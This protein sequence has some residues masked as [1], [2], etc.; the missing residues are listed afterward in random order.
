MKIALPGDVSLILSRLE[1]AG[2]EAY[3]VGGCIRDS[4]LGKV[5]KDWDV[6]TNAKPLEVKA[7]FKKSFDTG[8]EHGTVTVLLGESGYEITTYRVDGTYS[9]GRHP[10]GVTF[11]SSLEEDLKRR[12]FTINA[13]AYSP[14]RGLVD[15]FAGEQD[16]AQKRIRA[17]GTPQKRFMED[18]LR[19][20]RGIR[21]GAELGFQI[22][23]ATLQAMIEKSSLLENVSKERIFSELNK[24]LLSPHPKAMG[25]VWETGLYTFVGSLFAK[26]PPQAV[27]ALGPL[28]GEKFIPWGWFLQ[29]MPQAEAV[30][31]LRELRSDKETQ[32][33]CQLLHQ[34]L[35]APL[36]GGKPEIR[37]ALHQCGREVFEALLY[38]KQQLDPLL[39]QGAMHRLENQYREILEHQ[40][41]FTLDMLGIRG[42][43]LLEAG[44]VPG[45][46]LGRILNTLLEEVM[47]DPSQN[48]RESLLLRAH[49]LA[50][51]S[52]S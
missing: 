36:P 39:D 13:M 17:V 46:E 30:G 6:T 9:D 25:L 23:P 21:F 22:D 11:S 20:L 3:A 44:F 26:I 35:G 7:L 14:D 48:Q 8:I 27:Q 40:D 34:L 49:A 41:P 15:I 42:Q 5:P 45:K 12:D 10:D 32:K 19:M 16:L 18:A 52:H 29:S 4:L 38:V 28:Q 50:G 24:I 33:K 1:K 47:E 43:D 51:K 31:V 2:F 37:R